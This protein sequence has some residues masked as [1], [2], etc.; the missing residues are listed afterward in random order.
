MITDP[1]Y[2][3]QKILILIQKSQQAQ[4]SKSN[5]LDANMVAISDQLKTDGDILRSAPSTPTPQLGQL[6]RFDSSESDTGTSSMTFQVT[7]H[8]NPQ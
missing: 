8:E 1:D 5:A 2:I 7:K 6:G 3:N 4:G